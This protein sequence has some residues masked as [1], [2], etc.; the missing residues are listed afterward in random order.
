M[1]HASEIWASKQTVLAVARTDLVFFLAV[2]TVLCFGS[3]MRI[4]LISHWSFSCFWTVLT[5]NQGLVSISYCAAGEKA[6]SSQ[7]L[8][9]GHSE[10]SYLLADQ[11][12][13]PDLLPLCWTTE[14]GENW[15]KRAGSLQL[16]DWMGI[17]Q[18]LV[19]NCALLAL[20]IIL[21]LFSLLFSI[22]LS[23]FYFSPWVIP[24]FWF[25]AP[26]LEGRQVSDCVVFS[27][28]PG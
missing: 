27:F 2:D 13:I 12:D 7:K 8:G 9:R 3:R 14:P 16:R 4:M 24:F 19:S 15:E 20:Y 22:L 5:L 1:P 21:S 17:G 23:H 28:L 26:A 18:Q 10:G 25:S 11:R 6:E